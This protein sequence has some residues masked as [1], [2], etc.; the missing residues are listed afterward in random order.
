MEYTL[1]AVYPLH[2]KQKAADPGLNVWNAIVTN[3]LLLSTQN[4][5]LNMMG[6]RTQPQTLHDNAWKF[7]VV[8]LWKDPAPKSA[9]S[10]S[11]LKIKG[12]RL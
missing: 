11:I 7:V 5:L 8:T 6:R 3:T 9:L 10:R 2:T 4:P 1:D 12:T